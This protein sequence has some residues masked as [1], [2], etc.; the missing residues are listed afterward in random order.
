MSYLKRKARRNK[1][2]DKSDDIEIGQYDDVLNAAL[3]TVME[4]QIAVFLKLAEV[5][6]EEQPPRLFMFKIGDKPDSTAVF[7]LEVVSPLEDIATKDAISDILH[8]A[9]RDYKP[10]AVLFMLEGWL[11]N[12]QGERTDQ[13][14]LS[15]QEE[16]PDGTGRLLVYKLDEQRKPTLFYTQEL[17]SGACDNRFVG[18]FTHWFSNPEETETIVDQRLLSLLGKPQVRDYYLSAAVEV[19]GNRNEREQIIQFGGL[20]DTLQST[21]LPAGVK[22][23]I[24]LETADNYRCYR[25]YSDGILT[26]RMQFFL[27]DEHDVEYE[28]FYDDGTFAEY[29]TIK[30]GVITRVK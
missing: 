18:R 20:L 23:E 19:L 28:R 16:Y 12:E 8:R 5:Q 13:T 15:L 7:K 27:N 2:K 10:D 11:H 21:C 14:I 1:Q 3:P 26:N 29:Y 9:V 17:Q 30:D 6:K 22:G 24:T 25:F 4:G